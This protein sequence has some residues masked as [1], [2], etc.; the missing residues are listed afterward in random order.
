MLIDLMRPAARL[1]RELKAE[2]ARAEEAEN[3]QCELAI[4]RDEA[5]QRAE[6][7][8]ESFARAVENL[9]AYDKAN[10]EMDSTIAR[11][12]QEVEY[13][14]L[15]LAAEKARADKAEREV[16][17]L[18]VL[19]ADHGIGIAHHVRDAD[20]AFEAENERLLDD[21]IEAAG[22]AERLWEEGAAQIAGRAALE[23]R[24][25][26]EVEYHALALAAEKARADRWD[27]ACGA[28]CERLAAAI[29][30]T[31]YIALLSHIDVDILRC[32]DAARP[33]EDS[34]GGDDDATTPQEG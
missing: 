30:A 32:N 20:L 34:D 15:A 6:D 26:Q 12:R 18:S 1:R 16:R 23:A 22:E 31:E 10:T 27:A 17:R 24:M 9:V 2:K 33:A 28:V 19:M 25:R 14:A 11:V 21:L 7:A 5:V 4:E 13:H 3:R 29:P 8:A